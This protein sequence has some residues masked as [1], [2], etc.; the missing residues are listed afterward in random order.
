MKA[1][2][3]ARITLINTYKAIHF[4]EYITSTIL[5]KVV[6]SFHLKMTEKSESLIKV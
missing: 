6:S 5:K 4:F 1:D 2:H 3:L